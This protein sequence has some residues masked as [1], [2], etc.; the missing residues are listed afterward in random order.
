MLI[1]HFF[2]VANMANLS[3]RVKGGAL[4]VSFC[5]SGS[6]RQYGQKFSAVCFNQLNSIFAK[7]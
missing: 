5:V 3:L 6:P 1:Q 2:K 7:N 4:N